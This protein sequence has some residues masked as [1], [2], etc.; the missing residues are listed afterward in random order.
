MDAIAIALP[1]AYAR[2]VVEPV[3]AFPTF[4]INAAFRTAGIE[5]AKLNLLPRVGEDS[6]VGAFTVEVGP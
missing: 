6:K 1:R 4:Q 2:Q 3:G 5:Q